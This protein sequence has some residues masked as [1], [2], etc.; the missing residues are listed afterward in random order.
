MQQL[1]PKL[2]LPRPPRPLIDANPVPQPYPVQAMG[3]ILG[4][5][6]SAGP[7]S[8]ACPRYWPAIGDVIRPVVGAANFVLVD[9][10]Q[11]GLDR[12][13]IPAKHIHG[14]SRHRAK[15]VAAKTALEGLCTMLR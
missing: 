15:V 5:G 8:L 11:R 14:D 10:G 6:W 13:R 4:P 9:S 7:R 12:L 3:G 1:D 2:E